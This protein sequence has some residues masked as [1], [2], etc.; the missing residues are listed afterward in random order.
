MV[1]LGSVAKMHSRLCVMNLCGRVRNDGSFHFCIP[2][3]DRAG[4]LRPGGIYVLSK[5]AATRV[6]AT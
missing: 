3:L 2:S 1:S 6:S 5:V 4:G